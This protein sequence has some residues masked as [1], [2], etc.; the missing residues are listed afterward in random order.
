MLSRTCGPSPA[1][2]CCCRAPPWPP[3]GELEGPQVCRGSDGPDPCC[4]SSQAPPGAGPVTVMGDAYQNT[5]GH[6]FS[7]S[8]ASASRCTFVARNASFRSTSAACS[9]SCDTV[10]TSWL[11]AFLPISFASFLTSSEFSACAGAC[12]WLLSALPSSKVLS[13]CSCATVGTALASAFRSTAADSSLTSASVGTRWASTFRSTAAAR[14]C[15]CTME[16]TLLALAFRSTKA[17]SFCSC[18][19]VGTSRA[20]AFSCNSRL[21]SRH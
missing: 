6:I 8:R 13:F 3:A 21:A 2:P 11:F 17:D 9:S 4:A 18:E 10:G 16:G 7:F 19:C 12:T 20:L 5:G 1:S 14:S 15:I